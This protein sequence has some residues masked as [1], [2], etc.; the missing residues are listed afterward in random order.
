MVSIEKSMQINNDNNSY[1][2]EKLIKKD[3]ETLIHYLAHL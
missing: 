3:K 2:L 1:S